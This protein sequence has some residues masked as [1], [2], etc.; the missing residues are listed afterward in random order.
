MVACQMAL[1]DPLRAG[2]A[3]SAWRRLR[4]PNVFFSSLLVVG[5]S[6]TLAVIF[7]LKSSTYSLAKKTGLYLRVGDFES[8]GMA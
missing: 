1:R 4:T 6:V 8:R 3:A 2:G 5:L 7:L